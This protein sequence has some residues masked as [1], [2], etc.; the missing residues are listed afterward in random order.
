LERI[1]TCSILSRMPLPGKRLDA[2]NAFQSQG[3]DEAAEN[4]ALMLGPVPEP[5]VGLVQPLQAIASGRLGLSCMFMQAPGRLRIATTHADHASPPISVR[6][7]DRPSS[8]CATKM[9]GQINT[10]RHKS[11]PAL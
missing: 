9:P 4:K 8:V 10:M 7:I 1:N 6:M 2:D 11:I 5:K 3:K